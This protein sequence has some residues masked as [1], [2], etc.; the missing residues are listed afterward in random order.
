MPPPSIRAT[1]ARQAGHRIRAATGMRAV[2]NRPVYWR[3]FV[4]LP[5]PW[6]WSDTPA[7]SLSP[8]PGFRPVW[9]F[10]RRR[11]IRRAICPRRC[12]A[13]GAWTRAMPG[14]TLGPPAPDRAR[15]RSGRHLA[16]PPSAVNVASGCR[17][18]TGSGLTLRSVGG[19]RARASASRR[20]RRSQ[21]TPP[22]VKPTTSPRCVPPVRAR[23]E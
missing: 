6:P 12:A 15:H 10:S 19:A 4:R 1:T 14:W 9:L 22:M 20:R 3:Y 18:G 11:R 8:I 5:D 13:T 16:E 21:V 7:R 17:A 2:T 23:G